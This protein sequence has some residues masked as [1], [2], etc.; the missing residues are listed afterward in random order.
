[1]QCDGRAE[2]PGGRRL[3][4]LRTPTPTGT[5]TT[6][7]D[8]AP[9]LSAASLTRRRFRVKQGTAFRFTVSESATI[10]IRITRHKPRSL[11]GTLK[12][13]VAQG[14]QRVAFSGR[15]GRK[16]LAPGGYDA[17]VTAT[18]AA[19]NRSRAVLLHFTI[20]RG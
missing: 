14:P 4:A 7:P 12:R 10:T 20:L 15:F 13:K 3:G 1:M 5:T 19:G 6:T 2:P 11:R 17:T 9:R 16:A 18:D 8:A